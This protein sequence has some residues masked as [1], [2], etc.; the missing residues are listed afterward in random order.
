MNNLNARSYSQWPPCLSQLSDI[1]ICNL[2]TGA[3]WVMGDRRAW[4]MRFSQLVATR[5]MQ[6]GMREVCKYL[7]GNKICDISGKQAFIQQHV[8]PC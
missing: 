8:L 7:K 2:S 3:L 6:K 5:N 4:V 1:K